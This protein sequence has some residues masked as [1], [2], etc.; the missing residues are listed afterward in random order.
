MTR[1]LNKISSPSFVLWRIFTRMPGRS[2]KLAF[3]RKT[4]S[5]VPPPQVILLDPPQIETQHRGIITFLVMFL[6]PHQ[7]IIPFVWR[8]KGSPPLEIMEILV[9][10]LAQVTP[11]IRRGQIIIIII[12]PIR[13][14]ALEIRRHPTAEQMILLVTNVVVRD[15]Y[16]PTR[17][18]HN[19]ANP[20]PTL[21]LTHNV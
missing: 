4:P 7:E 5:R 1:C 6:L 21:D 18:V 12:R 8:Q 10:Q 3:I 2:R 15:I 17:H 19:M 11:V 9:L 13:R 14:G 20:I 16:P